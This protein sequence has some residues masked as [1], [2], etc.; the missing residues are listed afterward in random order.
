M[1]ANSPLPLVLV[2]SFNDVFAEIVTCDVKV[3]VVPRGRVCSPVLDFS[4][5]QLLPRERP[6]EEEPS[7][8][9][10]G[11]GG[12]E[13]KV[14]RGEVPPTSTC[15]VILVDGGREEEMASSS[16]LDDSIGRSANDGIDANTFASGT[17]CP[18]CV[19][20]V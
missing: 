9:G 13:T 19:M 4:L 8:G 14:K 17:P 10:G 18:S 11:G 1:M 2:D 6:R 12:E 20:C 7:E 3:H 5:H 16:P 15:F